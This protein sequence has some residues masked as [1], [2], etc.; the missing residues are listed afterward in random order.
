MYKRQLLSDAL[1]RKKVLVLA[2]VCFLVSA[3]GA[4]LPET[5]AALVGFRIIGGLGIGAASMTSP[6][7][8]AEVAPARIRGR[9]VALN[10]LAIVAGMLIVYFVNY[11]IAHHAAGDTAAARAAV[12][13]ALQTSDAASCMPANGGVSPQA[14][15]PHAMAS[16]DVA[17]MG[18]SA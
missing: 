7:Y 11:A 3:V 2:A 9:M 18:L 15:S 16:N 1:G 8:I 13:D 12:T 4:A 10:Q 6:L 14:A 5:L 17:S